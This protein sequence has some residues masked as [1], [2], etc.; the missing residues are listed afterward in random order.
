MKT[1]SS[2]RRVAFHHGC[3]TR[4]VCNL[5]PT[6]SDH[7]ALPAGPYFY[8]WHACI[9]TT[10]GYTDGDCQ[11]LGLAGPSILMAVTSRPGWEKY[12]AGAG[13]CSAALPVSV[14]SQGR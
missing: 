10:H 5:D 9:R 13:C 6:L 14:L 12:D 3:T 2:Y 1:M 7:Q 4:S 8:Q 11:V